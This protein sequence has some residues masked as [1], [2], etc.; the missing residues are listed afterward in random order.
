MGRAGS[1][2]LF[3]RLLL[4][5]SLFPLLFSLSL[6]QKALLLEPSM[7]ILR[8]NI[9]SN[10]SKLQFTYILHNE[11][12]FDLTQETDM[13]VL[14]T[15]ANYVYQPVVFK[16]HYLPIEVDDFQLDSFYYVVMLNGSLFPPGHYTLF[17]TV[18]GVITEKTLGI[19]YSLHRDRKTKQPYLFIDWRFKLLFQ[20]KIQ[21]LL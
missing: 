18:L 6:L 19:K 15:R 9:K 21:R 8:F 1:Q 14:E 3:P 2:Q 4:V 12:H 5:S 7:Y 17:T 16:D 10:M 20:M 11:V 13:L